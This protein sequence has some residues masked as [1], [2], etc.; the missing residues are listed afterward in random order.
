M[1]G[2]GSS[3]A[4][5]SHFLKS[6]S[7]VRA[8]A[9]A[10]VGAGH[11]LGGHSAATQSKH[12]LHKMMSQRTS[13]R[14]GRGTTT[15][16]RHGA[17]DDSGSGRRS[18][19]KKRGDD[20]VRVKVDGVDVTPQP[21]ISD[22]RGY[23]YGA[24]GAAF[25]SVHTLGGG[26]ASTFDLVGSSSV[27]DS[28]VMEH[29]GMAGF[30]GASLMH[31]GV[32]TISA[33]ESE[34]AYSM[35]MGAGGMFGS[36]PS[37]LDPDRDWAGGVAGRMG[38]QFEYASDP[39]A[40]ITPHKPKEWTEKELREK[41]T[42]KIEETETMTLLHIPSL[43]VWEEDET[44]AFQADK[45]NK[46]YA[47]VLEKHKEKDK[48]SSRAAQTFNNSTREK[49]VQVAPPLTRS[50]GGEVST[51]DLFDIAGKLDSQQAAGQEVPRIQHESD[52][53]ART[54]GL[55]SAE[56]IA[57]AQAAAAAGA[58]GG[59]GGGREGRAEGSGSGSGGQED[60]DEMVFIEGGEGGSGGGSGG[61]GGGSHASMTPS[62]L[63]AHQ[64][65]HGGASFRGNTTDVSW[66]QNLSKGG[67]SSQATAAA[68]AS[69]ST[70]DTRTGSTSQTGQGSSVMTGTNTAGQTRIGMSGP[71]GVGGG[72]GA[73]LSVPT[74]FSR[75]LS[76][77]SHVL[78][79]KLSVLE[80]AVLQSN[81]HEA[82]LLYRNHPEANL[83]RHEEI[84]RALEAEAAGKGQKK[85]EENEEEETGSSLL[86]PL[87]SLSLSPNVSSATGDAS[88]TTIT[89]TSVAESEDATSATAAPVPTTPQLVPLWTFSCS[90]TKG[91]NVTCLA[92]NKQN[93]D[94]LAAGYGQM[95]FGHEARDKDGR[96]INGV[97]VPRLGA[98]KNN[99]NSKASQ[100]QP[101]GGLIAFWS[102]K[103]P[104]YPAKVFHTTSSVTALDFSTEHPHLLAAGMYDGSVAIYDVRESNEYAKAA[105]GSAHSTGKH[106]EAVWGVQWVTKHSQIAVA[107]GM[108]GMSA[109][110][111]GG[112]KH[113]APQ[114]LTS[115]STDGTVKQWS[116][117]KGLVPHEIM[118]LKRVPNRAA[119]TGAR[120]EGVSRDASG[121]CFDF[122]IQDGTQ[123]LAGTEDGLIHKCSV[124]YNEQTLDTFYGH[125][126]P[127]YKIRCSPFHSD[128]FLSCSADWSAMLWS[129]KT[130]SKPVL[131][132]ASA[133]G[134]DAIMDIVWCPNHSCVCALVS[135]DGRVEV[136]DLD[137]SPLDPIIKYQIAQNDTS[138]EKKESVLGSSEMTAS[139]LSPT[140]TTL[141]ATNTATMTP[142]PPTPP[143]TLSCVSFCANAPVLLVGTSDGCIE[144]LRI[145]GTP[146]TSIDPRTK[147][148]TEERM[149]VGADV[150][151]K[152]YGQELN[153]YAITQ[154]PRFEFG[155]EIQMSSLAGASSSSSSA[156][157]STAS[158]TAASS[159]SNLLDGQQPV[160]GVDQQ[161]HPQRTLLEVYQERMA[162][163]REQTRKLERVIEQHTDNKNML[164]SSSS[165][166]S[167]DHDSKSN[168]PTKKEG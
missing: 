108:M 115:I 78:Q 156:S 22:M 37:L 41:V 24:A 84:R 133:Q 75:L 74:P 80:Q 12:H 65:F 15:V 21:L 3:A 132:L 112:G 146:I 114:T 125:T 70:F 119:L 85:E 50:V 95:D 122:P 68:G 2:T 154:L 91:L 49:E 130:S 31:G 40:H 159:R 107:G 8:G 6:E 32:S 55:G 46:H 127:V 149:A 56:S 128:A 76:K 51:S 43:R 143:R 9:G 1:N 110:A 7:S 45:M 145:E 148:S 54:K 152:T 99:K 20:S 162:K 105:L 98:A 104:N 34:H 124:S 111:A 79:K 123:Y 150:R 109:A 47:H 157:S 36:G 29:G 136:W 153:A 121:L 135:R 166:M 100:S 106:S 57:A 62:A 23:G 81:L 83:E 63:S 138:V 5:G 64:S 88:K 140:G 129:Q 73:G 33:S 139:L 44:A 69:T 18:R 66:H 113:S 17:G 48:Y 90:L 137:S 39:R 77:Y 82:Q 72:G 26:G 102:L 16:G 164:A 19:K 144:L 96:A 120:M 42:I 158:S 101:Q 4:P 13:V 30:P 142:Q 52:L 87:S 92:W 89:V 97:L 116:M 14:V 38:M 167:A 93:P 117:K 103:N 163:F 86:P 61:A 134:A 126:A 58:M 27:M 25:T 67:G 53:L 151:N 165:S 131:K 35:S 160:A 71:G 118:S 59:R 147:M 28:S 60:E 94:L 11:A 168:A 10:G 155:A 161:Q 141:G